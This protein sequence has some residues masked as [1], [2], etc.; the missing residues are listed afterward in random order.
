MP[1]NNRPSSRS[2]R[3]SDAPRIIYRPREDATPEDEV[4]ALAAVFKLCLE[5]RVRQ[6]AAPT[7]RPKDAAKEIKG[8]CDATRIISD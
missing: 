1:V 2:C 4:G 7:N 5:S 6:G 8:D 3:M